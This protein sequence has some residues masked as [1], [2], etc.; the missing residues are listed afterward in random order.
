MSVVLFVHNLIVCMYYLLREDILFN[1]SSLVIK[2]WANS[3]KPNLLWLQG[4]M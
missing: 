3:A 1:N 4:S 2:F